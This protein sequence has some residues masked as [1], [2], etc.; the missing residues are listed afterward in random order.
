VHAGFVKEG[1]I[2]IV[3]SKNTFHRNN[4]PLKHVLRNAMR[5]KGDK[6]AGRRLRLSESADET[7]H[8]LARQL[9]K[10]LWLGDWKPISTYSEGPGN[11]FIGADSV[12]RTNRAKGHKLYR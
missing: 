1:L 9:T 8:N 12:I 4:F 3:E 7:F 11:C 10:A 2:V 5:P 6:D